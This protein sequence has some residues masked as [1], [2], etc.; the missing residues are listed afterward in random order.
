MASR[1]PTRSEVR[2]GR[3]RSVGSQD[4]SRR[5]GKPFDATFFSLGTSFAGR[6]LL[7]PVFGFV[8]SSSCLV[9]KALGRLESSLGLF[10]T[11]GTSGGTT[12]GSE[13]SSR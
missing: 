3:N 8:L 13:N 6:I 10:E 9:D 4:A 5:S 11:T 1:F 7:R 12:G 2:W